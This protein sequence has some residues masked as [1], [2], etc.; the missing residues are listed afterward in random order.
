[1]KDKA[2][3][4]GRKDQD[5]RLDK[6][7]ELLEEIAED[8][9]AVVSALNRS[10]ESHESLRADLV[11]E[12]R[13]LREELGGALAYRTLKDIC[14]ELIPPLAAME[15]ML[16]NADFADAKA[17]RSHVDSLAI[18]LRSVLSRMGAERI[19]VSPGE[20]LFDPN[21]HLCV[22]LRAP[23]DSPFPSAPPRTIVRVVEDGYTLAGRLLSPTKV[24]V[25]AESSVNASSISS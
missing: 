25:Q 4:G 1:M 3:A 9:T 21:R 13:V 10:M 18:T 6:M 11:R 17:T 16:D 19:S 20:E 5:E 8:N 2:H 14:V 12:V 24:E 7:A 15:A 23:E 22:Q